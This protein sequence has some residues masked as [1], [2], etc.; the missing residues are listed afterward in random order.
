MKET[1]EK[2]EGEEGYRGMEKAFYSR[3]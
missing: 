1:G 2:G 3:F